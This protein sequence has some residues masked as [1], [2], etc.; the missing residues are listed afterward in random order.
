MILAVRRNRAKRRQEKKQDGRDVV[1]GSGVRE[2]G[3][4]GGSIGGGFVGGGGSIGEGFVG[5]G[6]SNGGSFGDSAVL[7]AGGGGWI[8]DSSSDGAG[9]DYDVGIAAEA[10]EENCRDSPDGPVFGISKCS[11]FA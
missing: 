11:A 7:L 3:D 6:G 1:V 4:R 5:G 10:P 9:G 8:G 2:K